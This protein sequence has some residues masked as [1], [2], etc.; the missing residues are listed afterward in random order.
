M[1]QDKSN[2]HKIAPGNFNIRS[3]HIYSQNCTNIILK[4]NENN[5]KD[6]ISL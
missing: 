5:E 1:N 3:N 6:E 2:G 4:F